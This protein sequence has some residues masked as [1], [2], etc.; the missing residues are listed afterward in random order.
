ML[1]LHRME[2]QFPRMEFLPIRPALSSE[3]NAGSAAPAERIPATPEYR[4]TTRG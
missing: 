2:V 4:P 3:Q 1:Y